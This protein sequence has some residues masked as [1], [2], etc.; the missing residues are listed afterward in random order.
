MGWRGRRCGDLS[1]LKIWRA[2][3]MGSC[4]QRLTMGTQRCGAS[5]LPWDVP[6]AKNTREDEWVQLFGRRWWILLIKSGRKRRIKTKFQNRVTWELLGP[7]PTQL[8]WTYIID[9][10]TPLMCLSRSPTLFLCKSLTHWLGEDNRKERERE[11]DREMD[12]RLAE[13][14]LLSFFW[15][16]VCI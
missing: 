6:A 5:L 2:R 10:R 4:G 14:H 3:G 13:A 8:Q 9:N 7:G 16:M 12:V 15:S 1:W 11:R